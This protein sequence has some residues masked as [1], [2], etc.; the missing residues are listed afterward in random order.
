MP[1]ARLPLST[2]ILMVCQLAAGVLYS[3]V[4]PYAYIEANVTCTLVM[5]EATRRI[6][7][8]LGI[9][10]ASSSSVYG[11]NSV[12]D[13]VDQPVSLYAGTKRSSELIARTCSHL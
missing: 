11:A 2:S 9:T 4:N 5:L 8:L 3:L 13:R 7:K 6:D 10:Y 12:A 1:A